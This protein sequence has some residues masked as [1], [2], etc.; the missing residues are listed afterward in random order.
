MSMIVSVSGTG[1]AM[2]PDGWELRFEPVPGGPALPLFR[3]AEA[4]VV[5]RTR[6][7]EDELP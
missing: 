5:D 4:A 3:V 2:A 7:P 6:E 1:F